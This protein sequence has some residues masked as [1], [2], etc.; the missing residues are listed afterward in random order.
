MEYGWKLWIGRW[1]N[2]VGRGEAVIV[3]ESESS[4]EEGRKEGRNEMKVYG[5]LGYIGR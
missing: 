3:A 5:N 1:G 4:L 2:V